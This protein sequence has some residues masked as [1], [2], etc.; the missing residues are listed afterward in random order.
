MNYMNENLR[1][2]VTA[3]KNS[4]EGNYS[5]EQLIIACDRYTP[6]LNGGEKMLVINIIKYQEAVEHSNQIN[7]MY[8]KTTVPFINI[9][10][11]Q[12]IQEF[13]EATKEYEVS[14]FIVDLMQTKLIEESIKNGYIIDGYVDYMEHYFKEEPFKHFHGYAMILEPEKH[15]NS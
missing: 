7:G 9:M 6:K 10:N 15:K 11:N 12:V 4:L 2:I 5:Y 13:L 14:R 8:V 1:N 3:I